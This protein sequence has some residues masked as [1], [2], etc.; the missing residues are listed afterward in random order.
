MDNPDTRL[1]I[2][3]GV[4]KENVEDPVKT[5]DLKEEKREDVVEKKIQF[6][7]G[8]WKN[9]WTSTANLAKVE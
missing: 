7:N 3:R 6:H 5:E 9:Q 2:L 1:D 4:V 8:L